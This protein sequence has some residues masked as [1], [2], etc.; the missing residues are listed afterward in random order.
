MFKEIQNICRTYLWT[1]QGEKSR[2]AP[3]AW[4]T[5]C[6]PKGCGGWN[7]KNL[8]IWN[9]V[10]IGKHLWA[11]SQKQ[12]K[13]W[14]RWLHVYYIKQQDVLNMAVPNRISWAMKKILSSRQLFVI[15]GTENMLAGPIFSIKAL[16]KVVQGDHL[17][18]GWRRII[19]NIPATPKA[20]F[21]TW[22]TLHGR[23]PTKDRL[24]A[25]VLVED[26]TCKLCQTDRESITHLCFS[27]AMA[28]RV[29]T[30][31]QQQLGFPAVNRNFQEEVQ[32]VVQCSRSRTPQAQLYCIFFVEALYQ[33]WLNRNALVFQGADMDVIASSRQILFRTSCRS[34]E[35]MRPLLIM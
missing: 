1:G 8:A 20:T 28:R 6:L 11:L 17:K 10:A 13:L 5:I 4:E 30:F 29:W 34:T 2:K 31:C 14:I 18:V 12:D 19:C 32:Y 3:V 24:Y 33:V 23:L 9:K 21:I 25:W 35:A 15:P 26:T 22:L 7:I 27:C 16:Y